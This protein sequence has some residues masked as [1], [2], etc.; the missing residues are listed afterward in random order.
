MGLVDEAKQVRR[1]HA[2]QGPGPRCAISRLDDDTRVE[3]DE[4]MEQVDGT[5]LTVRA[6]SEAISARGERVSV[7]QLAHHYRKKGCLCWL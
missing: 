5:R 2:L 6:V 7:S 1:Q 3:L 4:A